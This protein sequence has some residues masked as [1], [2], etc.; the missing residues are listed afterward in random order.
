[1]PGVLFENV[2]RLAGALGERFLALVPR[3]GHA[4]WL[5]NFCEATDGSLLVGKSEESDRRILFLVN[6]S[7]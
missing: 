5:Q 7:E 3:L 4:N 6:S 2:C 1:V